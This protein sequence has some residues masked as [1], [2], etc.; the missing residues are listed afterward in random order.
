MVIP[1]GNGPFPQ[2]AEALQQQ[3]AEGAKEAGVALRTAIE[4]P[5]WPSVQSLVVDLSG[6]DLDSLSQLPRRSTGDATSIEVQRF[7]VRANPVRIRDLPLELSANANGSSWRLAPTANGSRALFLHSATDGRFELTVRQS[8]LERLANAL[9]TEQAGKH[10]INV[11]Q[12]QLT[13]ISKGP[14]AIGLQ[15]DVTA[16]VMMMKPTLTVT[17][18]A[19]LDD[20][21]RLHLS[22]LSLSGGGMAASLAKGFLQPHFDRLQAH[23]IDLASLAFGEVRLRD[24]E[25]EVK[26]DSLRLHGRFGG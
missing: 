22:D 15:V 18:E 1:I 17:G 2:S 7:E 16:K 13:I 12:T 10:G 19:K 5:S 9:L 11:T 20:Q 14:R 24:V 23:P 4:A 8:E 25:L 3:M 21:L 6:S 26:A